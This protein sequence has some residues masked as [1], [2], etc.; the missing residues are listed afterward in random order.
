MPLERLCREILRQ[1]HESVQDRFLVILNEK[2]FLNLAGG[3]A[4][5]WDRQALL[6]NNEDELNHLKMLVRLV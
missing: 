2:S 1:E 5:I 3:G 6:K 4:V